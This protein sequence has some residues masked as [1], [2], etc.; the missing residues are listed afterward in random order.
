VNFQQLQEEVIEC[1]LC[2]RCGTC[3]GVCPL[4]SVEM[5]DPLGRCLPTL[6][7]P[8]DDCGLCYRACPGH[9]VSFSTLNRQVFGEEGALAIGRCQMALLAHAADPKVRS[10]GGSGGVV[11]VLLIEALRAGRVDGAVVVSSDPARPWMPQV[12]IATDEV[13]IRAAAQ[14][15]Y[16][17]A[18]VNAILQE[19]R[20]F[21]GK[22]IVVALPCQVHGLRKLQS[23]RPAL[24]RNIACIVGLYCGNTLYFEA[25]RSLLRRFGVHDYGAIRRLQY[26]AGPWPGGFEVELKSGQRFTVR[27]SAFNYLTPFYAVERCW[28]CID[29]CNEL[30]DISVGDGWAREGAGPDGWS[31]VIVRTGRGQALLEMARQALVLEEIASEDAARMH[32][33]GLSNKKT[34]AFLRIGYLGRRRPVPEYDL[35]SP[36][37]TLA[38]RAFER[39][40]LLVL[41]LCSFRI[42]KLAINR[43]PL[44]LLDL[45]FTGL[46]GLW[47]AATGASRS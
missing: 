7:G 46:R 39:F 29:L 42:S 8:C 21:P 44:P 43:I 45:A 40:N 10:A 5:R 4:S 13:T 32:A 20:G 12:R 9:E 47:R 22:L 26:R 41:W 1:G 3:V 18:P 34:G 6:T 30:A 16:A 35:D 23:I 2:T 37:V 25:T 15:K 11:T 28:L 38:R 19:T 14:S 27:K 24:I 17:I 36:Q 33:H 31:V